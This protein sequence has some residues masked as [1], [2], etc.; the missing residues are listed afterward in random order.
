MA[1]KSKAKVYKCETCGLV[2]TEKGIFVIPKKPRKPT[3]VSIVH[4]RQRSKAC[5]QAESRRIKLCL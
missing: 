2:T 3:L 4:Y 5:L 1:T